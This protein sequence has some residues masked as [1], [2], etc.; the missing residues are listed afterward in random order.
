M[1]VRNSNTHKEKFMTAQQVCHQILLA[2]ELS[3]V[4]TMMMVSVVTV[5]A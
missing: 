4:L 2:M 5:E 1:K 3:M